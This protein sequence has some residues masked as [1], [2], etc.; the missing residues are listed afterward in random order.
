MP[1]RLG[2]YELG[3][4]LGR[5]GAGIV[6]AA[7]LLLPG[8]GRKPVALKL[9]HRASDELRREARLGGLPAAP[10]PGG[11]LRGR[12]APGTLVHGHGA[13]RPWLAH[14]PPALPP[15]AVVEVGLAVTSALHY[16]HTELGL[17]HLDLKPD[18]LLLSELGEIKVADLGIARAEG[19]GG[20]GK[21]RGTPGYMAPEQARGEAVRILV[22][23]DEGMV[24]EVVGEMLSS[25]GHEVVLAGDGV[26]AV[27]IYRDALN[28]GVRFDAVLLDLTVRGGVGGKEAMRRLLEVDREAVGIVCSGYS[29]DPVMAEFETHGF[30]G[31]IAKP[32]VAHALLATL[33]EVLDE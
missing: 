31:R 6:Y 15:R 23:D 27:R 32:F 3:D 12:R 33:A 29:D 1:Q 10:P 14:G 4:E 7:E 9:L 8:G 13:L 2:R 19:F 18:N 16:A 11:H 21:I 26:E 20:D 28:D 5:G 24:R 22:M 17:V 30:K 25:S